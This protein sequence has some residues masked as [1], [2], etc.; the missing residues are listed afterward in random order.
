MTSVIAQFRDQ[1]I[2]L[3]ADTKVNDVNAA[4]S[5]TIPGCLKIVTF[6]PPWQASQGR[7]NPYGRPPDW[8]FG[9]GRHLGTV[10]RS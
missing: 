5:D 3:K 2:L 10:P 1:E 6:L 7:R 4:R 8:N 9:G